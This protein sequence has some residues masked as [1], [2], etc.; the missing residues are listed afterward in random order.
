MAGRCLVR[1]GRV[2]VREG[3]V[4]LVREGR[5]VYVHLP[6]HTLEIAPPPNLLQE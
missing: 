6:S 4:L 5:F 3:R 2:L 1:E